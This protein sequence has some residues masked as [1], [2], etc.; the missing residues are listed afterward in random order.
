MENNPMNRL[1]LT[2]VMACSVLLAACGRTEIIVQ[3]QVENAD[4][5][6]VPLAE[7]PIRILPY[8][9]DAIFDS[10]QAAYPVPKPEIPADLLAMRDSIA[11]A[12]ELWTNATAR[13]NMLRDSLQRM[14][15]RLQ[16]LNRASGEYLVLFREVNALFDQEAA[17]NRQMD[18]AFR[19]YSGLQDRYT[20]QAEAI[21]LAREQWEDA[22]FTDVEQVIAARLRELR[23]EP[24]ADT[25]DANGVMRRGVPAG[26]W[27]VT[28]RY[29]MPF[30]ELYWNIPVTV[31]RGQQVPVEL[32]RQTA[33]VR[34]KL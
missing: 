3:A 24:L 27:W 7:L 14:N 9:R 25:L 17:A 23:R 28:A 2:A 22:A 21:R 32:T 13:W 1:A 12:Q 31:G 6:A 19:R 8:D 34:P 16:G 10:L 26:E 20:T 30:E 29:D 15:Q 5:Q 33:V 18:E 4:G 11:A